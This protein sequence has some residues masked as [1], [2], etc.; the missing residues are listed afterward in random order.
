LNVHDPAEEIVALRAEIEQFR[1]LANNVPAAIAYYERTGFTC[2]YAN[3]GY[4]RMFGRDEQSI[5]GLTFA[6]VI[7]D[8][9]ARQIQPQVDAILRD[10][11]AASYER[12]L[13]GPA[14]DTRH[15][16]VNLLPHLG[17]DGEAVGAFVLIADITRHRRAELALRESEERLAKFMHASAE[18]IV[19]HKGGIITDV[20]P[21]L[22]DLIGHTLAE[23]R[24]R[25]ALD[26]VAPD[27]RERVGGVMAA[28]AELT[29]ETAVQHQD[30]SRLP[31]EFIVRTMQYQGEQL[32]MTIVRDLRDR[33]EA[34]SRIHHLAHH[35]ALTGLPNR[36]AFIEQAE[37]LVGHARAAGTAM[38][39]LFI[40]LDHFKRVNDSLGHLAG[41][42]LLKTVA[43]RITGALRG[44]D[45]VARFGGD[46]FVAL[47]AGN[48]PAAAVQE[49]AETLLA[50]VAAPIEMEG[51]SISVTPSIGVALFP[52][53]GDSSE[54]LIKHA[55]TAMYHAKSRG[56][57][58]SRFFEPAMAEEALA[59]LEMESRLARAIEAQEFVLHYQPQI[60][61]ADGKL[62]GF[63]ALIRWQHPENGLV[64]PDA[65]I[66]VAESRRL[67]LPIGHWVLREALREARRWRDDGLAS[68]PVAVNLSTMQFGASGFVESIER[69]LADT[70]CDGA[71]LELELTE[72]MLMEDLAE[73]R[74]SL[75]RLKALGVCIAVD[76]FG[77]GYTSLGHL[78]SLPIDRLKIDRSFVKDL[79]GDTGSAAIAH[80]I[81]QMA[82]SLGLRT[83]AEGVENEAQYAWLRAQGCDELQGHWLAPP[84]S[85]AK[86][87]SW[88][89]GGLEPRA[90]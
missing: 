68:V 84:M 21:P 18:G 2:R 34:R 17:V 76:D 87:R 14:G 46:E 89:Q 36:N 85:A 35:D 10:R 88:L 19:F 82:R 6:Q 8:E 45:L 59:A 51:A 31:V 29:Y 66:P 79:P 81:I 61:L 83:L 49:V 4:A 33:I 1:L 67:M 75:M 39:L 86:L 44:G 20:N 80:A 43:R 15:I 48:P 37:A 57:A 11:R 38:A 32:R 16:E 22:L 9:A 13:A 24:G 52:R 63:E 60:S 40:D 25:P 3:I 73:V 74:D 41:D 23:V 26:F 27:Q 72:R 56:R 70:G 78:K 5:I 54:D 28:A 90:V 42:A 71:M 58:G 64:A 69:A 30:G 12:Q 62:V 47:L 55:D 77:T 7:G 50:I 65:F 53:D